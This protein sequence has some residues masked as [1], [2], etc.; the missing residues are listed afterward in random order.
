MNTSIHPATKVSPFVL[1][2]GYEP[3]HLSSIYYG[4]TSTEYYRNG[5]H[6]AL[7]QHKKLR[8]VYKFALKN[9]KNMETSVA[10]TWN[11]KVKY[12][13]FHEGQDVYYFHKVDNVGHKKIRSPYHLATVVKAYPADVYLIKLKS[14]GKQIMSSYNKLTLK[15]YHV[16]REYPSI[17]AK[18][19]DREEGLEKEMDQESEKEDSEES[20]DIFDNEEVYV[21]HEETTETEAVPRRSTRE[22]RGVV[23]QRYQA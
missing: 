13:K 20:D 23:P 9:I 15:P 1:Q 4:I 17:D 7:E 21:A 10:E 5:Q 22:T 18:T 19:Q 11:L 6:Y 3:R 8:T 14:S 16:Q 12:V 2:R